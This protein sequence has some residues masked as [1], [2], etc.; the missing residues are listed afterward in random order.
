M[1]ERDPDFPLSPEDTRDVRVLLV[2]NLSRVFPD[3]PRVEWAAMVNEVID[4]AEDGDLE[5][6]KLLQGF[7]LLLNDKFQRLLDDSA[8]AEAAAETP[9]VSAGGREFDG[10]AETSN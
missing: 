10:P 6:I 7:C 3:T 4:R 1:S 2:Q 9:D 5:G 8:A